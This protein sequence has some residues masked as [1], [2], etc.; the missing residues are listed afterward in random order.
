MPFFVFIDPYR[1]R[2]G[3]GKTCSLHVPP[4]VEITPKILAKIASLNSS[5]AFGDLR[6]GGCLRTPCPQAPARAQSPARTTRIK[7]RKFRKDFQ[8]HTYSVLNKCNVLPLTVYFIGILMNKTPCTG[9]VANFG[10]ENGGCPRPPGRTVLPG[11]AP[12]VISGVCENPVHRTAQGHGELGPPIFQVI[13]LPGGIQNWHT[14]ILYCLYIV[15]CV[16]LWLKNEV[17]WRWHK[18]N[19]PKFL[20]QPSYFLTAIL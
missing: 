10:N 4:P 6:L 7:R 16:V 5:I 14:S 2:P 17:P 20:L 9:Q 18:G 19:A 3:T 13:H 8:Y 15:H 11:A 1:T 12:I